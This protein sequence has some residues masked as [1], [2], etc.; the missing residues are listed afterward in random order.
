MPLGVSDYTEIV[1]ATMEKLDRNGEL[2]DQILTNHPATELFADAA[3]SI[4]GRE[5]IVN[6]EAAEVGDTA[7]TDA[8]GTFNTNVD[9]EIM[10][11]ARYEHGNPLVSK[12]RIKWKDLQANSGKEQIV[13]L[14]KTH[15]ESAKKQH[16]RVI[17][18][19]LH[20]RA[21]AG[22]L[23]TGQFLSFDQLTGDYA[24]DAD[25][26]GD[27][28]EPAFTVGGITAAD[29]DHYWNASRLE[30]AADDATYGVGSLRK[31]F[32][33]VRNELIEK[34]AADAT[35]T[36]ILAGRDIFEEYVDEL[37]DKVRYVSMEKGQGQFNAVY[38]GDIELRFDPD[39]PAKRAYFLD[40][41]ALRMSYLNGNWMKVQPAQVIT[42]TLD[43]VIPIA[44][45][46]TTGTA[47]RRSAAVLL[48]PAT[49]GGDA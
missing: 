29:A 12:I 5:M 47:Q 18:Q 26:A 42:G 32:R 4:T 33:R 24:Y 22:E 10:G 40:K 9:G 44:S 14:L 20:A 1:T 13:D 25:P 31:V 30:Y 21:G 49:A 45:V 46:I 19:A 43:F 15:I 17:A 41:D 7:F 6:L 37:D 35:V 27:T 11:A 8:S 28:T 36:H 34:N 3:Q 38:D 2:V 39:A 23:T 48:R 16:R